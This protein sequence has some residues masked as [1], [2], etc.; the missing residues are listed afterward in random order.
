MESKPIA[1]FSHGT[2]L[3]KIEDGSIKY[4][5]SYDVMLSRAY[6]IKEP[7]HLLAGVF[8]ATSDIDLDKDEIFI[9]C[10]RWEKGIAKYYRFKVQS[11]ELKQF[12]L[13]SEAADKKN[14]Y[15]DMS[16]NIKCQ[17]DD[18]EAAC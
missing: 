4:V 16:D 1:F 8:D 3:N 13:D 5:D 2:N 14:S 7:I 6:L 17:P 9:T 11:A 10:Q 15:N 12:I 18:C